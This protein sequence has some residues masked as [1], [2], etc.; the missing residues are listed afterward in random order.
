[1]TSDMAFAVFMDDCAARYALSVA[2]RKMLLKEAPGVVAPKK[3]VPVVAHS[4]S[5]LYSRI[6]TLETEL[7][8]EKREREKEAAWK[9][10]VEEIKGRGYPGLS[11]LKERK[12]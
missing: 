8:R 7:A 2:Y 12:A 5:E 6:R 1:M 10:R 4:R 9:I 3:Q 11:S